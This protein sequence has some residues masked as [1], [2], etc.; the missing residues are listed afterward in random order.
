[1]S[2]ISKS[3]SIVLLFLLPGLLSCKKSNTRNIKTSG[4][5]AAP[6]HIEITGGT[7]PE[8][9]GI[10]DS[11][12]NPGYLWVEEDSGNPADIHL[13]GHDGKIAKSIPLKGAMNR[14]WEDMA[15]APGPDAGINYI[16]LADIGDNNLE[17]NEYSFYRFEEPAI[18][19]DTVTD[20]NKISF[21]YPDGHHDAEA[22]VVDPQTKDIYVITKREDSS[23]V[24]KIL[25]P[26]DTENINYAV[27]VYS[28]TY[29]G[30][31]STALSPDGKD[32][33]VKTYTALFYY[34]R[35]ASE[36]IEGALKKKPVTL[37]Y[38]LEAQGE[39]ISFAADNSGFYTL[40]EMRNAI[41]VTLNFYK[42]N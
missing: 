15:L 21:N 13:L 20:Y 41:P 42:R 36:S 35:D 4:F 27:F 19:V 28:L 5:S 16:Y 6:Q 40:S 25:Y 23:R 22:F 24:Y 12:K 11:K 17:Y 18:S 37:G 33:I 32:L 14:D 3:L 38:E 39:A 29:N 30:V 2:N 8:A 1:M 9:S 34:P 26:Q 31:V 10:A 7:I